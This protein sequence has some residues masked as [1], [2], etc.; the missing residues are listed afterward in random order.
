MAGRATLTRW[1]AHR[2]DLIW[3]AWDDEEYV[4]F[5]A[6]SGNT[7]ILNEVSAL[8]LKQLE[9]G[10]LDAAELTRRMADS[11]DCDADEDLSK[12]VE[13]LLAGFDERGLAE[14]TP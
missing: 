9:N 14:R 1:T 5:H 2:G 7:H 11:L 12:H 8:A 13:E 4:V 10:P 6:P 3:R